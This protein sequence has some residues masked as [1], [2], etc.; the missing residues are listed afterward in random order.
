VRLVEIEGIDVN[1]CG[2][3][4]CHSTAELEALKLLDCEPAR[5][6]VRL[7]YAAGA[8]LRRLHGAHHERNAEL[9]ALLGV[10]D[11][12]LVSRLSARLEQLKEADRT[13]RGLQE[14]LAASAA[15]VIAAGHD[16]VSVAHWPGRELPFL[17]SVARE[18]A[19]LDPDRV[20]LLT[21][22]E[23]E[24]GAFVVGTGE[25]GDV[26]L[27]SLGPRVAEVLG[28]RGGGSGGIFQGKATRLSRREAAAELLATGSAPAP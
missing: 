2:G 27:K 10:P 15:A 1:T 4:H 7:F 8:R 14:E 16:R 17:Q 6:G 19:R 12:E 22:G 9:R 24:D 18:V 23:G 26:D 28:G 20:V 11:E 13:I 25:R 21:C 5:G 3:T